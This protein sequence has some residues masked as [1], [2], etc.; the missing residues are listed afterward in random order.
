MPS[1]ALYRGY[2]KAD[3]YVTNALIGAGYGIQN[4]LEGLYQMAAHPVNTLQGIG[5]MVTH[6][7][8]AGQAIWQGVKDYGTMATSG[9]LGLGQAVGENLPLTMK[10]APSKLDVTAYHGTADAFDAFDATKR[11]RLTGAGSA[12]RAFWFTEDPKT[13]GAYSVYAAEDGPI[14]EALDKA[15]TYERLAQ[16]SGNRSWWDKYD[17]ALAEAESLDTYAARADRRA[18]NARVMKVDIPDDLDLLQIDAG[19]KTPQDLGEGIDSWL[20][21]QLSEAKRQGKA[22]V[23]ITNLD[24]A[25]G[26]T[27]QP[28]TH[29]AIFDPSHIKVLKDK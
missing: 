12:K 9:P 7:R 27:N 24:D 20:G 14:K 15:A 17:A 19:G 25:V 1:N 29:Y 4:Q 16:K 22:G 2:K 10:R 23:K 18:A 21:K 28:A 5:A 3:E 13:A 6:P 11:G 8:E 26:M